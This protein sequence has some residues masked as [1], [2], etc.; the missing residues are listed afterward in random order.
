MIVFDKTNDTSHLYKLGDTTLKTVEEVKYLSIIMQ[1]GLKFDILVILHLKSA[2]QAT[3][4]AV[5][6]MRPKVKINC[7]P[8]FM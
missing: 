2:M 5:S 8:K 4:L 6:S 3:Y 7:I 1:S